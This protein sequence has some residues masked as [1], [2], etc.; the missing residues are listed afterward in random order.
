[1]KPILVDLPVPILTPR[2]LIRPVLA[3]DGK[4]INAAVIESLEELKPFMPWAQKAPSVEESEE[5]VRKSTAQWILREDLRLSLYD[6]ESGAYIGGSGLHRMNWDVPSFE[7]GYWI[8]TSRS[9]QGYVTEATN[10]VARYAFE[11]LG[12]R[13]VE[14]RIVSHNKKSI[15][16]SRKLG[17]EFEGTLR[18]S[19]QYLPGEVVDM[20]I[21]SLLTPDRLPALD[22]SWGSSTTEVGYAK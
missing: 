2:L 9:G 20:S 15:G 4:E 1:M 18:N 14:I 16:I 8:R 10:A 17:F 7:I 11:Q 6:R 21:Y 5:S 12:A 13:R 22:V 3:G 19:Q